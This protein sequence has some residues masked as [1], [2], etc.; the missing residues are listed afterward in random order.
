[1][2]VKLAYKTFLGVLVCIFL[3]LTSCRSTEEKIKA[4]VKTLSLPNSTLLYEFTDTYSGATGNCAG[5][6]IDRWYGSETEYNNLIKV[7]EDQLLQE[8]WTLWPEDV[9]KIWR[10]QSQIGLFSI[11]TQT[12]TSQHTSNP[13]GQYD[14]P[15]SFWLEAANY[16]TVYV[17]SISYMDAVHTRRCLENNPTQ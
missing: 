15:E 1:M 6:F 9:V 4:E 17:V 7:Y 16:P 2:K 11:Y 13:R 10:K 14:L 8:G 5:R 3:V 12:L